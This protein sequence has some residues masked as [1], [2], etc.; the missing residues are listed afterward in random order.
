M[1][2]DSKAKRRDD[3][4][5][6]ISETTDK[7][8]GN[9]HKSERA[10]IRFIAQNSIIVAIYVVLTLLVPSLSFSYVQCRFSE[11][12]VLICF[13]R[14]DFAV[15]L[16]LGCL[17]TNVVGAVQGFASPFDIVLGSAATLISCLFISFF[18][19]RLF[20]AWVW[21]VLFNALIVGAELYFLGFAGDLPLYLSCLYVG[22]GELIA[23]VI[24]YVFWTSLSH[25]KF[26]IHVF[27]PTRHQCIKW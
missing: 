13:W 16:T 23:I 5:N 9:H 27:E 22:V 8:P 12:L 6:D 24:G 17:I 20:I 2:N 1:A 19:K 11:A 25:M 14:P 21:P 15:G 26:F 3:S 4:L 10:L 18:S 7:E